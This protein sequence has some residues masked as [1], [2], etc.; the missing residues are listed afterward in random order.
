MSQT[1][2]TGTGQPA[3]EHWRVRRPW[4]PLYGVAAGVL[5]FVPARTR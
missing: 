3:E 2:P 5:G 1:M 4:W